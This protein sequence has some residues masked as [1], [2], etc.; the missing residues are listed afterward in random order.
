MV[1]DRIIKP[2]PAEGIINLI[3]E[4]LSIKRETQSHDKSSWKLHSK[5]SYISSKISNAIMQ[6]WP[7]SIVLFFLFFQYDQNII[8][9][10]SIWLMGLKYYRHVG[11]TS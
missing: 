7:F 8:F 6:T 3:K 11:H 1:C 2:L 4:T 5:S 9:E 10:I